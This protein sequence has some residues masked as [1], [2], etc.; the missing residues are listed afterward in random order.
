MLHCDQ[1]AMAASVTGAGLM[2]AED[3]QHPRADASA[4][5]RGRLAVLAGAT[6]APL[7]GCFVATHLLLC[8]LCFR[9][10]AA[11]LRLV[12]K[13]L[14]PPLPL[15][16]PFLIIIIPLSSTITHYTHHTH[17]TRIDYFDGN[18]CVR[19]CVG[20]RQWCVTV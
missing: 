20:S 4:L 11:A 8:L 13:H 16:S 17:I 7:A 10:P 2:F 15:H 6:A 12:C 3:L 5:Q 19:V 14:H 1:F 9:R 18:L